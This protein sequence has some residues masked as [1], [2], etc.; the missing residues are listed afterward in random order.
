MKTYKLGQVIMDV[1]AHLRAS[2]DRSPAAILRIVNDNLDALKRAGFK[3]Q[4][5]YDQSRA[6]AFV[7]RCVESAPP[8]QTRF[9][10]WRVWSE[11]RKAILCAI[12]KNGEYEPWPRP[13]KELG[14]F[15]EF[16]SP[17]SQFVYLPA[18][19]PRNSDG[20]IVLKGEWSM[21]VAPVVSYD[22]NKNY[23]VS[24]NFRE[25]HFS[26]AYSV[27]YHFKKAEATAFAALLKQIDRGTEDFDDSVN[28]E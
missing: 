11:K 2:S 5:D 19:F 4:P 10:H 28:V 9:K 21:D 18:V 7:V 24:Q 1:K 12:T 25:T 26:G 22:R 3:L 27:R 15:W 6:V 17:D 8:F 14:L 16:Q 20:K 13:A 23:R